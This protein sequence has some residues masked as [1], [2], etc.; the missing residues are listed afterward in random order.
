[1]A[2][3]V[4]TLVLAVFAILAVSTSADR[5]LKRR[6]DQDYKALLKNVLHVSDNTNGH[7]H[8]VENMI[9]RLMME[10][11]AYP[12]YPP[13]YPSYPPMYPAYPPMYPAYPP[14]YPSYPPSYPSYPPQYRHRPPPI[15]M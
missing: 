15:S 11:M 12:S 10:S 1:M 6:L 4:R 8:A 7:F 9:G 3:T 13:A 5:L 2:F 14:A